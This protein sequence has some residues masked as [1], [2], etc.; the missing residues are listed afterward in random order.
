M[1]SF[2]F[3]ICVITSGPFLFSQETIQSSGRDLKP[4]VQLTSEEDHQRM[5]KLLKIDSLRPGPSGNP[6]SPH[7]ANTDESKATPYSNLPD[8]LM[9]N[10]GK[11]VNSADVWR[12]QRRQE[13]FED[14]DREVYGR[15][16]R[17]T[18]AVNWEVVS[19]TKDTIGSVLASIKKNVGHVDHSSYPFIHVDIQLTLI[20]PANA[21]APVP[22]IMEFGFDFLL[23]TIRFSNDKKN[24]SPCRTLSNF[25]D[26][27]TTTNRREIQQSNSGRVLS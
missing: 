10:N 1:K 5:M 7:A 20:T 6:Q 8:P 11:K 9:L 18:P 24:N 21:S 2:F 23:L 16:P 26:H 3:I 4:P 25:N 13:I 22:V 14:F 17:N 15:M 27:G 12:N 19:T